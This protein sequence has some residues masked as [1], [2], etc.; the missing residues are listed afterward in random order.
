MPFTLNQVFLNSA[1]TSSLVLLCFTFSYSPLA[2]QLFVESQK[3]SS[4]LLRCT[5]SLTFWTKFFPVDFPPHWEEHPT[6]KNTQ[7]ARED[8]ASVWRRRLAA[9]ASGVPGRQKGQEKRRE[10]PHSMSNLS[11]M[12]L[13][14]YF[15]VRS[16]NPDWGAGKRPLVKGWEVCRQKSRKA[17]ERG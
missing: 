14:Q 6:R 12:H 5:K 7:G 16:M 13:R 17:G 4:I 1:S 2:C 10:S 3:W 8:D 15:R 9:I 11:P